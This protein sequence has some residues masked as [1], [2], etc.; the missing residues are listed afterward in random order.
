M[1]RELCIQLELF[2]ILNSFLLKG[3]PSQVSLPNV[4]NTYSIVMFRPLETN[5]T[6]KLKTVEIGRKAH[7][8]LFLSFV[9]KKVV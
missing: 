9:E 8:R 5:L 6:E 7:N 1:N 3:C 4:R 2:S